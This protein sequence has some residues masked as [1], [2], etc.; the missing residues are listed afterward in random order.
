MSAATSLSYLVQTSLAVSVLIALVLLVRRPFSKAFG[1]KA[2]YVLW[3]I[4]L[5]RLIMPPLP[6]N[7]TLFGALQ[8]GSGTD[9][10]IPP[11]PPAMP[12]MVWTE[13]VVAGGAVPTGIAAGQDTSLWSQLLGALSPL[14]P[15]LIAFWALGAVFVFG[16]LMLRQFATARL[17][18]AEGIDA[19]PA[20]QTL[21]MEVRQ[22]IGLSRKDI[23]IQTSFISSGPLVAGVLRPIILLPAWFEEDYSPEQQRLAIMHEMMHVRR[24]DLW[25]LLAASLAIAVQWFNPLAWIAL[26]KFRLDQEAAC[27][28]DV[29]GVYDVSPHAYGKALVQAVRKTAPVAQPLHAAS[30]PLNHALYERIGHMKNP[31]PSAKRRKTGLLLTTC[32]GAAALFVSACAVSNAQTSDPATEL[33]GAAEAEIG[34][35]ADTQVHTV[36]IE[37]DGIETHELEGGE[38]RR[39]RIITRRN[40]DSAEDQTSG[41]T[42]VFLGDGHSDGAHEHTREISERSRAFADEMRR[43]SRAGV[44]ASREERAALRA[45]REALRAEFEADIERLTE[46]MTGSGSHVRV[47]QFSDDT[48]GHG[49]NTAH[50][51]C[52]SGQ[53]QTRTVIVDRNGQRENHVVSVCGE[54]VA[55]IDADQIMADLRADGRLSEEKLAEVEVKLA[56]AMKKLEGITF[57]SDTEVDVDID[58]DED[59]TE[60]DIDVDFDDD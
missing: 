11:P 13:F 21:A 55:H 7:W 4:P 49:E 47:M 31:L 46:N 23:A 29:L 41:R 43:L 10:A 39:M 48:S 54:G 32:V 19:G 26:S 16:R 52:G 22:T 42:M 15:S 30:L 14:M 12:E 8:F 44:G 6:A 35:E 57:T 45:E 24:G 36:I 17:I 20:L 40:G 58:I 38:G 33:D 27:D 9:A 59:E 37:E 2:V 5:A 28:A 51:E 50:V 18:K 56:E 60:V 3:A 34:A 25:A 1:N 53:Q